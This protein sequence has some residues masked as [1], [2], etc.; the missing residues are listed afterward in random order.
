MAVFRE[1][2]FCP[3]CSQPYKGIYAH[4]D[5]PFVGDDFIGWDKEGHVCVV[6][7]SEEVKQNEAIRFAKWLKHI[8]NGTEH[9][10]PIT[11]ETTQSIGFSPNDC[12]HDDIMTVEELY[13]RFKTLE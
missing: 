10:N 13:E 11:K 8:D 7:P 5:T 9:Y 4:S 12:F 6:A 1:Q 2:Q 3:E